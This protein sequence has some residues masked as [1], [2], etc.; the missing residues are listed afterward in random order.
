MITI[1]H[2]GKYSDVYCVCMLT[3][4]DECEHDPLCYVRTG[5]LK[6]KEEPHYPVP[7]LTGNAY[8]GKY[9]VYLAHADADANAERGPFKVFASKTVI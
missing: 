2:D 3:G 8:I 4:S 6:G 9:G 7:A 5:Y 1:I